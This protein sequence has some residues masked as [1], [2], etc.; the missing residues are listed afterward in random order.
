MVTCWLV[1]L[2][3]DRR[4]VKGTS[5]LR[6]PDFAA[7]QLENILVESMLGEPGRRKTYHGAT[8][9]SSDKAR[10]SAVEV[11]W[12]RMLGFRAL[13]PHPWRTASSYL[14]Y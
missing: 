9:R 12:C 14:L 3:G 1:V 7:A 2:L 5:G 4:A 6:L 13:Y 10:N 8:S 11:G